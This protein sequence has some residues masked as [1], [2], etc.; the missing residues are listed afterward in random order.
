[1]EKGEQGEGA[2]STATA[3]QF[4]TQEVGRQYGRA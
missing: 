4:V 3:R 2:G 1:M